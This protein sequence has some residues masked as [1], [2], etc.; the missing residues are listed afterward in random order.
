[1][2]NLSKE[3]HGLRLLLNGE[4]KEISNINYIRQKTNR[5]KSEIYKIIKYLN[6]KETEHLATEIISIEDSRKIFGSAN[7][8]SK[9]SETKKICV[10]DENNRN[11]E[12]DDT[13]TGVVKEWFRVQM[14]K[15]NREPLQTFGGEPIPLNVK[16]TAKGVQNLAQNLTN[17]RAVG[18][19]YAPNKLLEF[20]ENVFSQIVQK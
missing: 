13:K 4:N 5:L 17:G 15:G 8:L 20:A 18:S 7:I 16:T 2:E 19:D 9:M 10:H 6:E 14:K 12:C 3:K 11:I 1:M